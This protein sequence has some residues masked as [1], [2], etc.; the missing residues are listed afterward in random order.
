MVSLTEAL[1]WAECRGLRVKSQKA[2][3]PLLSG[4]PLSQRASHPVGPWAWT[5]SRSLRVA[6]SWPVLQSL[7]LRDGEG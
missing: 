2:Q 6:S 5:L 1:V 7:G 3:E 4:F